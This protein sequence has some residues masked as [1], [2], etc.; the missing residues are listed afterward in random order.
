MAKITSVLIKL[1]VAGKAESVV[2]A[3]GVTDHL[4]QRLHVLVEELR[5]K[6]RARVGGSHQRAGSGGIDTAFHPLVEPG[7]GE[8]E[9][10]RTLPAGHVDDLY[11]F[12][13]LYYVL[14]GRT[15]CYALVQP[16]VGEGFG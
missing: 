12:A 15:P 13:R 5:E 7:L 3:T 2:T 1:G 9:K 6:S 16:G 8:G 14:T 11:V 10:I 4:D